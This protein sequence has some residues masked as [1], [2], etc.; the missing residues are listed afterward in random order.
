MASHLAPEST[1]SSGAVNVSTT[2]RERQFHNLTMAIARNLFI[3]GGQLTFFIF[4]FIL[5]L[6][7]ILCPWSTLRFSPSHPSLCPAGRKRSL[8]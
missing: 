7:E 8:K 5:L 4:H 2:S 6:L 1:L 3:P